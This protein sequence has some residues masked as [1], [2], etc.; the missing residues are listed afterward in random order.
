MNFEDGVPRII[1]CDADEKVSDAA[2]RQKINVPMACRDGVCGT[3]KC[4][5]EPGEFDPCFYLEDAMTEEETAAGMVLTCQMMP[6]SD[7]VIAI[8]ASSVGAGP[9]EAGSPKAHRVR[10][11][12]LR[13]RYQSARSPPPRR[14]RSAAP[15][16]TAQTR[17]RGS[18]R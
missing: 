5:P 17:G 9:A 18:V 6:K 1:D 7:Y 10:R 15:C 14:R 16:P 2:F 3:C 4:K 13:N 12:P 8:P 11:W